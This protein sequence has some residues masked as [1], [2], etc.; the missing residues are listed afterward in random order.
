L[1][2]GYLS[3][4]VRFIN[5]NTT[6]HVF[7]PSIGAYGTYANGGF[8]TD[9]M[10]KTEFLSLNESFSETLGSTPPVLNAGSATVDM[11]NYIVANNFNYRFQM[12]GGNWIEPTVGAR[13]TQTDYGSGAAALGFADGHIV[14]VQGG[15][16]FGSEYEWNG[17]HVTP[18]LTGLAYSDVD[19]TG[20]AIASG[21]FLN[22]T[23]FQTDQG[24]LRGQ[25]I[26]ALNFD[27]KNGYTTFAQADVR[28]GQD[29]F[30]YS[31][32]LGVRYQW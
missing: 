23:V 6:A 8:S 17:I 7:G 16:R 26:F 19:I 31:G 20:G 5:S 28:G 12:G 29:Y 21:G 13:F 3:S 2:T 10:F 27:L 11:T 15:A 1:V 18:I 24:K 4:D 30:G 14:R 25:G 22:P 9:L 32:K